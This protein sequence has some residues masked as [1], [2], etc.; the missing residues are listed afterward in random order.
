MFNKLSKEHNISSHKWFTTQSHKVLKSH[1]STMGVIYACLALLIS[2]INYLAEH[3]L[4]QWHQQ[5]VTVH[6]VPKCE[7]PQIHC[8]DE[9]VGTL[10]F[11]LHIIHKL[12]CQVL[13][14][15]FVFCVPSACVFQVNRCIENAGISGIW[16]V[17]LSIKSFWL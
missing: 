17:Q 6:H 2:V 15:A 13:A 14:V 8:G 1:R 7:L 11:W 5:C 12:G 3:S 4:V 10:F 9:Q 16:K